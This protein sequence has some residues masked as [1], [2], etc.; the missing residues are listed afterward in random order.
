MYFTWDGIYSTRE[1]ADAE[2][3]RVAK[4]KPINARAALYAPAYYGQSPARVTFEN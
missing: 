4:G 2:I 3:A 1:S